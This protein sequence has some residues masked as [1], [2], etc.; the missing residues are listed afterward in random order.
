[1]ARTATI[2][3]AG[4]AAPPAGT[5]SGDGLGTDDRAP[6][7]ATVEPGAPRRGLAHEPALDGL[8]GAAMAGIFLFHLERFPGGFL[9]VDLFFALS[10]FLITSLLLAESQRTDSV[11][12]GAFW[13]RRARRLLPALW[14]TLVGVS[15]LVLVYTPEVER[16]GFRDGFLATLG[17]VFNW[18][19]VAESASYWDL[20]AQPSPLEHMW[21]LAMEKQFYLVWPLVAV[22]LLR[23]RSGSPGPLRVVSLAGAALAVVW[24]ALT[25]QE[26]DTNFAYFSTVTRMAPMLLGAALATVTIHQRRRARSPRPE[27]DVMAG[28]ALFVMA[29]L[30]LSADGQAPMYYRGGMAVFSLCSC[31]VVWAVTGGPAGLVGRAF[32]LAPLQWLG[33]VSYGIYLWHWPVIV[34]LTPDRLGLDRW[35][36]DLARIATTLVVAAVSYR[37]LEQPIRRGALPGRQAWVAAVVAAVVTLGVVLIATNGDDQSVTLE[38]TEQLAVELAEVPD[39]A[40][41]GADNPIAYFPPAGDIP[42]GSVKVLLVGDSGSAAWGPGLVEVAEAG[43]AAA[44]EDDVADPPGVGAPQ[45]D[46]PPVSAAWTTQYLCSIVNA[47]GPILAPDGTVVEERP[48]HGLRQEVWRQVLAAYDPDVV[49]YHLANAGFTQPHK[50]GDQEVPECHPVYDTYLE[51]TLVAEAALLS[52]AGADFVFATSPYTATLL[53]GTA[54][55]V[56]CRNATIGRAA[57][58][59]PG[60]RVVDLNGWVLSQPDDG[61]LFKDSV[62]FSEDGARRAAEWLVPQVQAWY[63]DG[64]PG[65]AAAT[66]E[67]PDEPA[68]RPTC[69]RGPDGQAPEA[70]GD[71]DP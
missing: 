27:V 55:T 21:T 26:G 23:R 15:V 20:F 37:F 29:A 42:D 35:A 68:E 58:R 59:V 5:G 38:E 40:A 2:D 8:R 28:A 32:S 45:A 69:P 22:A 3:A 62:H 67:R 16:A 49:V 30:L 14:V 47:D 18:H 60:S 13:A 6:A 31:V 25:Y 66:A 70:D 46:D 41:Q 12:L 65:S 56:D 10:G 44:D 17:Y 50:V 57:A 52:G 61:T 71:G 11:A 63:P 19:R 33:R 54:A 1:M 39:P 48:C 34:Y 4:T 36:T 64:C 24:M 51:D 43:Q 9:T 53:P 7:A